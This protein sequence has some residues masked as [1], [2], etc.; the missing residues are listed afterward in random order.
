MII[1]ENQDLS[2]IKH[3]LKSLSQKAL[4]RRIDSKFDSI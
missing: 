2:F 3:I 1:N 4:D